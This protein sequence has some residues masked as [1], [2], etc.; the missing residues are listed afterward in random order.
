[1]KKAILLAFLLLLSGCFDV[2][3]TANGYN[4]YIITNQHSN[5]EVHLLWGTITLNKQKYI[6]QNNEFIISF[7]HGMKFWQVCMA[8]ITGGIVDFTHTSYTCG[9]GKI[10]K[11]LN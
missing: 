7:S 5:T 3:Y 10:S 6:C 8:F 2:Y 1:M 9:K 4:N 11:N